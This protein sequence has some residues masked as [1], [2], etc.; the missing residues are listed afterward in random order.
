MGLHLDSLAIGISPEDVPVAVV[1][2]PA[3]R[4]WHAIETVGQQAC[5]GPLVDKHEVVPG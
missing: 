5:L 4:D 3:A 2:D 1:L